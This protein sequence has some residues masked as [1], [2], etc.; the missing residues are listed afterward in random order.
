MFYP[1]TVQAI[2]SLCFHE[3]MRLSWFLSLTCFMDLL[4]DSYKNDKTKVRIIISNS[5]IVNQIFKI[6]Q[7]CHTVRAF[8]LNIKWKQECKHPEQLLN[9]LYFVWIH[10]PADWIPQNLSYGKQAK[11]QTKAILALRSIT[12]WVICTR[13]DSLHI[14][15][16][17][18]VYTDTPPWWNPPWRG[19][20]TYRTKRF[21]LQR[22]NKWSSSEWCS[23]VR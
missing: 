8:R 2:S 3:R 5:Q 13:I 14:I 20:E 19:E 16:Y 21:S 6:Q 18:K 10:E 15:E 1:Q 11:N 7:N 12:S 22:I 4:L 9:G 23:Y 17:P